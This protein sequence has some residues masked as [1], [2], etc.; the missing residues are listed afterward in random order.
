MTLCSILAEYLGVGGWLILLA[1]QTV[2]FY[3]M[4]SV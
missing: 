4:L 2:S 3:Y 1:F